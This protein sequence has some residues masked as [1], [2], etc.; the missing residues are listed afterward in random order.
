MDLKKLFG[1]LDQDGDGDTDLDDVMGLVKDPEGLSRV[2]SGSGSSQEQAGLDSL[3][4]RAATGLVKGENNNALNQ[5]SQAGISV[6]S[7]GGLLGGL[8]GK[9]NSSPANKDT[10]DNVLQGTL[11]KLTGKT[12]SSPSQ[13]NQIL[14]IIV[15]VVGSK[16]A[17]DMVGKVIKSFMGNMMSDVKTNGV[18]QG[19]NDVDILGDLTSALKT[20]EVDDATSNDIMAT[21]MSMIK[22]KN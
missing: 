20:N 12:D 16:I 11:A 2:L 21:I 3:L 18:T 9:D 13:G 14:D 10:L 6:D 5:L 19:G 1:M 4:T 8:L 7:L 22:G 17:T 15:K